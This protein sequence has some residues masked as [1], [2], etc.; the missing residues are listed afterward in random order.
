MGVFRCLL[1]S[2]RFSR[3]L[4]QCETPGVKQQHQ[5]GS[6]RVRLTCRAAP[7]LNIIPHQQSHRISFIIDLL[8]PPLLLVTTT[9]THP[10]PHPYHCQHLG[11]FSLNLSRTPLTFCFV[12]CYTRICIYYYYSR[13][14]M[15]VKEGYIEVTRPTILP[16]STSP[17]YNISLTK[18][19][20]LPW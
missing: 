8:L 17:T 1:Y 6:Y 9:H 4:Q 2:Q 12:V 14:P 5:C 10:N 18:K 16:P 13:L 7:Y 11:I 15:T 19:S 3:R 20:W